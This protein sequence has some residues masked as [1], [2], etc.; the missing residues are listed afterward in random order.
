M[1]FGPLP[2]IFFNASQSLGLQPYTALPPLCLPHLPPEAVGL[3]ETSNTTGIAPSL[4]T[5]QPWA[6]SGGETAVPAP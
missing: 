3:Q 5:L 1:C 2:P 6:P 4:C